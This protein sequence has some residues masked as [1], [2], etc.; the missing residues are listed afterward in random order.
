MD[1]WID[2]YVNGQ[3]NKWKDIMITRDRQINR[4]ICGLTVHRFY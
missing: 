2:G 3:I 4:W 1:E